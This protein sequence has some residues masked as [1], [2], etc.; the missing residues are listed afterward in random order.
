MT[1]PPPINPPKKSEYINFHVYV[2]W[3]DVYKSYRCKDNTLLIS[4]CNSIAINK[5][6]D[7]IYKQNILCLGFP[8][9]FYDI[10]N[11]SILYAVERGSKDSK[12][13]LEEYH[14]HRLEDLQQVYDTS[15]RLNDVAKNKW[16]ANSQC[17]RMI[18]KQMRR[19]YEKQNEKPLKQ[20]E[21]ETKYTK[22]SM[23]T[24]QSLPQFWW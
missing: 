8:L 19:Y 6:I 3:I 2:P 9:K 17:F 11:G 23:I 12:V 13:F 4:I 22:P 24:S 10:T 18:S 1:R 21:G 5:N 7:L 20:K 16:E 14:H 15:L